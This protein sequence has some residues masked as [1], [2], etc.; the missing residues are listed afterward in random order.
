MKKNSTAFSQL[1]VVLLVLSLLTPKPVAA[2]V[3]VDGWGNVFFYLAGQVLGLDDRNE[4]KNED[5]D[6]NETINQ[7][8]IEKSRELET[9]KKVSTEVDN[10]LVYPQEDQVRVNTKKNQQKE[11]VKF[12]VSSTESA[13]F[14]DN[15]DLKDE[16]SELDDNQDQ[17]ATESG[18]IIT[19]E[20]EIEPPHNENVISLRSKNNASYVIR[21]K[22]AAQTH[23]PLQVNLLTNELI[24][25]TP[26]GAKIVTVLPDKAVEHMLAANVLDEIGGKGG[27][28]WK[29]AQETP[30]SEA[31]ESGVS[32]ATDSGNLEATGSAEL[33]PTPSPIITEDA[34]N[35]VE[36]VDS[37][38]GVLS[39]KIVGVKTKKLLG[40]KSIDLPRTVYLSAETGEIITIQQ[41]WFDRLLSFLSTN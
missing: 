40:I 31:T 4:N 26:K 13:E 39:Y 32:E 18:E 11:G 24:V 12:I 8:S 9:S 28:L 27:I 34:K 30:T 20:V 25:T 36:L 7:D 3:I 16:N 21:N 29:Q 22:I 38:D 2:K 5:L 41:S 23:F 6:E 17:E 10:I 15:E 35:V 37:P 33:S 1:L 14:D 19:D